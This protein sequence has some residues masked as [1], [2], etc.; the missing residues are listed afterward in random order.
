MKE[1]ENNILI[2]ENEINIIKNND[3][4][5]DKQFINQIDNEYNT[6]KNESDN[7]FNNYFEFNDRDEKIIKGIKFFK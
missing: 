5:L 7:N 6:P 1:N 4:L 2:N 3:F